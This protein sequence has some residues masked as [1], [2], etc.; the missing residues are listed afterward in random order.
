MTSRDD[1]ELPAT[2]PRKRDASEVRRVVLAWL[3]AI[4]YMALIWTVSSFS[5][6][7]LPIDR[8]PMRDK[9]VHF[10]EYGALGLLVGHAV[11]RTAQT[12]SRLRATIATILVCASWGMLDEIHQVFVPGRSGDLLD[13]VADLLGATTGASLRSVIGFYKHGRKKR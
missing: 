5:I 12:P 13:F 1:A 3:P 10:L 9:G 6:V 7:P 8:V 4:A 11:L 2:A